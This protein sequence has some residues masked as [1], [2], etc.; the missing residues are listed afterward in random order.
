MQP[1]L[2]HSNKFYDERGFFSEIYN[3]SDLSGLNVQFVQDNLSFSSKKGTLRGLHFQKPPHEQAKLV[4]V[5]KGAIYDVAVNLVKGDPNYLKVT[6]A[7]LS[8]DNWNQFF[9]P[10]GYAHG[11]ITLEENTEVLYK[12]SNFYNKESDSGIIWSDPKLD[13]DWGFPHDEIH[14]SKKDSNLQSI[15]DFNSPF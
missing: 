15:K 8:E 12:V 9:I 11:F 13:I 5:L 10:A 6:T 14:T 7:Y 3:S 2:I 1:Q 4:R